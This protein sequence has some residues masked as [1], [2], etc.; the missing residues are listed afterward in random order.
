[1]GFGKPLIRVGKKRMLLISAFG[2]KTLSSP[3]WKKVVLM[4]KAIAVGTEEGMGR[5]SG[6][7]LK[8]K[9]MPVC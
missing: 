5:D 3:T 8:R 1:M 2:E 4:T 6:K 9:K 7:A